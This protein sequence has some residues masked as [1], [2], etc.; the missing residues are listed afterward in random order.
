MRIERE[1]GY[2]IVDD[3]EAVDVEVLHGWLDGPDAYWWP[4]G[5]R[6]EVL[7]RALANSLPLTVL[8]P[9]ATMAGFGRV[10]TDRASFAYWCDVYVAADHRGRGLGRWLTR[11]FVEHPDVA[12]CRR[13]LLATRDAHDVYASVGFVPIPRPEIFLEIFRSSAGSAAASAPLP[14]SAH[15]TA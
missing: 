14:D 4:D 5:I 2:A 10:V 3:P 8:A 13:L 12:D 7:E 15:T 11:A 1:D 6:R 9:D